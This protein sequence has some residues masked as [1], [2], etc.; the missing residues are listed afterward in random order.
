M[1]KEKYRETGRGGDRMEDPVTCFNWC[2]ID[3]RWK[4]LD[5]VGNGWKC[6]CVHLCLCCSFWPPLSNIRSWETFSPSIWPLFLMLPFDTCLISSF[7]SLL[8]ILFARP[9]SLQPIPCPWRVAA[10]V[11]TVKIVHH[12][13]TLTRYRCTLTPTE[14][15]AHTYRS[16]QI[17]YM[18]YMLI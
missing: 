11:I 12:S 2:Q 5:T 9:P 4:C 16:P 13:I 1:Q 3:E 14:P 7:F 6:V 8:F 15:Q 10:S 17:M 18:D